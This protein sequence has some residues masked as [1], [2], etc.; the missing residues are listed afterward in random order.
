MP[1][2]ASAVGSTDT[3]DCIRAA[4]SA[5]LLTALTTAGI[6]GNSTSFGPVIDGPGGLI[7]DRPSLLT[8]QARL[9]T[10]IGSNL[11]E[12]TLFTPQDTSSPNAVSDLITAGTTP[13]EI[14]SPI[15]LAETVQQI[16][17]LYPDTPA[18][19]SPFGTGNDTFGL[20]SEFKRVASVGKL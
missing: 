3:F 10:L 5:S 8:L 11:D 20:N 12:G 15:F 16:E 18:L 13:S 9:P 14:V 19:G 6:F 1:A 2:C 7:T 17:K 4:D